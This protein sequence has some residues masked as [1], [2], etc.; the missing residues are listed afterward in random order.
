[1]GPSDEDVAGLRTEGPVPVN[2][3]LN[4]LDGYP[5]QPWAAR[6]VGSLKALA[7]PP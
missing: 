6:I 3:A 5:L 2:R 7:P 4:P 1:M